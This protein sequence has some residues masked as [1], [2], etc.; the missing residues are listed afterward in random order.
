MSQTPDE[1]SNEVN[2]VD[3]ALCDESHLQPFAEV[4][5]AAPMNYPAVHQASLPFQA[6]LTELLG[7]IEPDALRLTIRREEANRLVVESLRAFLG[8]RAHA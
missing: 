1:M 7:R 4:A 8:G 2:L 6:P 3:W 5:D